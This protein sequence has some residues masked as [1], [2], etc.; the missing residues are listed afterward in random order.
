MLKVCISFD[1]DTP[2]G[3]KESFHIQNTSTFADIEGTEE[4]LSI[5]IKYKRY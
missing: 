1:Y 4:I 5:F 2:I 3:Y